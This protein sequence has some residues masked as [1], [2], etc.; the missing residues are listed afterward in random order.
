MFD[1]TD[2]GNKTAAVGSELNFAGNSEL[3]FQLARRKMTMARKE[4][5]VFLT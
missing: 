3:P 2:E 1:I 5:N 4:H